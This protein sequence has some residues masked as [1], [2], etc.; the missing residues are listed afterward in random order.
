[1]QA[2]N[3]LKFVTF[4]LVSRK[5]KFRDHQGFDYTISITNGC[6]RAAK[7]CSDWHGKVMDSSIQGAKNSDTLFILGSGPSINQITNAQWEHIKLHDSI[8]FNYWLAHEFVPSFFLLQF[9]KTDGMLNLLRHRSAAYS[10][11]PLLVRGDEFANGKILLGEDPKFDFLK[12][13][14]LHYL[15]EYPLASRCS[16][17]M[18][19]LFD[20]VEILGM[21]KH[22][23]IGPLVPKWRSTLG[24]LMSW[25]YQMGYKRLVLCGVDMLNNDH[26]WNSKDYEEKVAQFNLPSVAPKKKKLKAYSVMSLMDEGISPNTVP[27]YAT[28]L[29]SWMSQRADVQTFV[30]SEDTLLYPALPL[31]GYS[32]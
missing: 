1:M 29:A 22:G 21:L 25:G 12:A 8:G 17:E 9:T 19:K 4:G 26:F 23:K 20:H 5:K 6:D 3:V 24:L 14:E 10:K 32:S 31:Y 2:Y 27:K 16:V 30:S 15:R 7:K 28:G 13:H 18:Q 11:V